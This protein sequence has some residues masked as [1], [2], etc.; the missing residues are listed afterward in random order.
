[1]IFVLFFFGNL[2][3]EGNA[4]VLQKKTTKNRIRDATHILRQ[5]G[6]VCQCWI[7]WNIKKGVNH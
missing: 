6:Q 1:M 2:C 3:Y 5:F 4:I 7:R